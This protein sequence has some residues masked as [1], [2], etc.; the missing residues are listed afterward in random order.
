M[1]VPWRSEPAAA[2][3]GTK[4][5]ERTMR[6][7]KSGWLA[8]TAVSISATFSPAPWVRLC[9]RAMPSVVRLVCRS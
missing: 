6:P 2:C 5:W 9:A 7:R 8:S 1:A 3:S 4:E